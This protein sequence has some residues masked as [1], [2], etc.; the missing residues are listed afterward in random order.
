MVRCGGSLSPARKRAHRRRGG[1]EIR[2]PAAHVI[3]A[4]DMLI[5]I[6]TEAGVAPTVVVEARRPKARFREGLRFA[7]GAVAGK[8]HA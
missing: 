1:H 3:L 7:A 6:G 4:P 8:G 5:G 2:V